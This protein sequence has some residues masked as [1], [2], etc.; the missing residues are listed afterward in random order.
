MQFWVVIEADSLWVELSAFS[1]CIAKAA[2]QRAIIC[3]H[4]THQY[5]GA[6]HPSVHA[7]WFPFNI[8]IL[9]SVSSLG[10]TKWIHSECGTTTS[11]ILK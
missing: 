11:S 5:M 10:S 6:L 1:Q 2:P 3:K 8:F 9:S 7:V 4:I